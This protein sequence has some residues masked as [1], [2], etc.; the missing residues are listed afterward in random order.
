ME[1]YETFLKLLKEMNDKK[2][3]LNQKQPWESDIENA[4]N[5]SYLLLKIKSFFK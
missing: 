2:M 3:D 5:N 1:Y 4:I